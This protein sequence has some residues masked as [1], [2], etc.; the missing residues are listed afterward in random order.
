MGDFDEHMEHFR[1][2]VAMR[3][4][5]LLTGNGDFEALSAL[6][7]KYL[8]PIN[9]GP[10]REEQRHLRAELQR[11]APSY[12]V[13]LSFAGEDRPRARKIAELL[14]GAGVKVFFDEYEQA[15]LWGMNLYS[16]LSE[17]YNNKA[18]FCLMFVSANYAAKL[19]TKRERE[20][21]Q[22]RA[23]RESRE[24]ILPLR[25]D[26]TVIPGLDETVAYIDLRTV[27][28]EEVARLVQK[29]LSSFQ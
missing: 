14:R 2:P 12:D 11:E 4:S 29:K 19:W 28:E 26:D 21:A 17:I 10:I 27:P 7:T 9:L 5:S 22:A 13:A 20:A 8:I 25:L 3:L 1:L 24:Y 6:A 23:F 15:T 16:H 18:K